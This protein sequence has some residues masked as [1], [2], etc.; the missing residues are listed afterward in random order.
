MLLLFV[1]LIISR[2]RQAKKKPPIGGLCR[3]WLSLYAEQ[4]SAISAIKE[5]SGRNTSTSD[6][7]V[8]VALLGLEPRHYA[9]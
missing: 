2:E 5:P 6:G 3:D 4:G 1:L 8:L 9:L 7:R